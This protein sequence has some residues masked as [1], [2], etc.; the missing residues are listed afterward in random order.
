[1]LTIIRSGNIFNS[2]AQMLVNPVNC[3]GVMGKGLALDFKRR[4]P[5]MFVSYEALCRS[6]ALKPGEPCLFFSSD[7]TPD[8][9][10]FPTKDDWR[11]PSRLEWIDKGLQW[12]AGNYSAYDIKSVAFPLLGCGNGGLPRNAVK[13]MM[14]EN[15]G[16]LPIPVELYI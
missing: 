7:N 13:Q 3:V 6:H 8:I 15:L 14:I 10:L 16:R 11:N 1:M 9:L 5:R 4:Y 2:N 12:F